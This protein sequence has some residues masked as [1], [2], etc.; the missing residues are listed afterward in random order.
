MPNPSNWK[1]SPGFRRFRNRGVPG[2]A[3]YGFFT[4]SMVGGLYLMRKERARTDRDRKELKNTQINL[5]PM[6]V[7]E[8]DRRFL[9]HRKLQI[10]DERKLAEAFP[11]DIVVGDQPYQTTW[12]PPSASP[13]GK[14]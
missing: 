12:F 11:D 3:I 8:Q 7:A 1:P 2:I 14:F 9:R 10:E 4:I 6:L 13:V 5:I